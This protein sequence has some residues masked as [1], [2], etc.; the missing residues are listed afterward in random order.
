MC[1]DCR[2]IHFS[3]NL[4]C[5]DSEGEEELPQQVPVNNTVSS[6]EPSLQPE[7]DVVQDIPGDSLYYADQE[8]T[9]G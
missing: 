6:Y 1:H 7:Q 4:A 3:Y 9:N 5:L 8:H 2:K